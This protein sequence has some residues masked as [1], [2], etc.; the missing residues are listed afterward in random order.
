METIVDLRSAARAARLPVPRHPELEAAAR[1]TWRQRMINEHGSSRVFEAL[2]LQLAQAGLPGSEECRAFAAE[3][4]RHGVLCG[5]VLESLGEPATFTLAPC[6]VPL[7]EDATPVEAVLRNVLSI[8][9]MSETVAVSL[10]GAERLAMPDG[11]L[12]AV[13]ETILADEIGHARFGWKLLAETLPRLDPSERERLEPYLAVAFAHLERHELDHIVGGA[14]NGP[15]GAALGL[16]DASDMRG[17]FYATVVDVIVPRLE[18]LGL[19]A[20]RA[21]DE[22]V[23]VPVDGGAA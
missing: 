4:R 8:C 2:A 18:G 12:R 20:H 7:H 21:W 22:R 6:E 14:G 17:L 5:A 3:E 23:R 13:L 19:A 15:E 9:C 11:E 16:C 10:I 1:A